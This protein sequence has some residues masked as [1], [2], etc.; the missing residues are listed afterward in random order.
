MYPAPDGV[1]VYVRDVTKAHLAARDWKKRYHRLFDSIGDGFCIVEILLDEIGR[2]TDYLLLETNPAF[3][4]HTGLEGGAGR[5][6]RELVPNLEE[7]WVRT[8]SAVAI[9]SKPTY[10]E[11]ESKGL[12]RWFAVYAFPF[13][14]KGSRKVAVLFNNITERKRSEEYLLRHHD[15]LER[16]VL[17]RT[18][19][20]SE[21]N[22]KLSAEVA[23]RK[24]TENELR[25]A[26]AYLAEGERLSRTGSWAWHAASG[27]LYMSA[28]HY[29]ILGLTAD[30][31]NF[32]PGD[33]EWI[34]PEDRA[35]VRQI[36]E[37]AI[38]E[39]GEFELDARVVRPD[40][41]T[42]NIRSWGHPV[43]GQ[44]GDLLEFVGTI[45]DV[46]E[47]RRSE[48]AMLDRMEQLKLVERQ[49]KQL[50]RKIMTAQ[51]EERRRIARELHDQLGQQ[52]STLTVKLAGLGARLS[53]QEELLQ[54]AR[55][56]EKLVKQ[57]DADVESLV[58]ELR[59]T[60]L[61]DLGVAAALANYVREWSENFGIQADLHVSGMDNNSLPS[62]VETMLYRVAQEALNNVAKHS[63]ARNVAILLQRD[64]TRVSLIIE[65]DGVGFD[66]KQAFS[67]GGSGAGLIGMRERTELVAGTL[68]I[69]SNPGG[70][71]TIIVRVPVCDP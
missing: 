4:K 59:L 12:N 26:E 65:D 53:A 5:R 68:G 42:A 15:E 66:L 16:R 30:S 51:E 32:Y 2:P 57:I 64:S 47:R 1:C 36:F 71:V 43:L 29:R 38:R 22:E 45:M 62:E 28:E 33:L 56:M 23:Q 41:E 9:K 27:D 35:Q 18:R 37:R 13:G 70:G 3:H 7:L 48:K 21:L 50:L 61:D 17:E 11:A 46:T 60:A 39:K 6:A 67:A 10:F 54:E 8:L 34:H 14:S 19:E 49:R 31:K 69:E 55:S 44:A 20:L 40:G 63:K 52:L 25:R 58:W 24:C